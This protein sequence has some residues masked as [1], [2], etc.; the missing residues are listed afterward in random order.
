MGHLRKNIPVEECYVYPGAPQLTGG[1]RST[2]A[3]N[4]VQSRE[5]DD[6]QELEEWE[7]PGYLI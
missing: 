3:A 2:R 4:P 6:E 7:R 5:I 1:P